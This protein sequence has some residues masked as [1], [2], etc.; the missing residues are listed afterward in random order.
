[1]PRLLHP[2]PVTA[3]RIRERNGFVYCDH[4]GHRFNSVPTL[5]DE[6]REN[7]GPDNNAAPLPWE[8]EAASDEPAASGP[9]AATAAASAGRARQLPRTPPPTD[10]AN[11][12][13]RRAAD[14]TAHAAHT[15]KHEPGGV[16]G[17]PGAAASAG[18]EAALDSLLQ[19]AAT[20]R[21]LQELTNPAIEWRG[22]RKWSGRNRSGSRILRAIPWVLAIVVL[23]AALTWM[24]RPSYFEPLA[25]INALRPLLQWLC[26]VAGCAV[27]GSNY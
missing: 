6:I 27:P 2:L 17:I 19:P 10:I 13:P 21:E 12:Q 24:M 11:P 23:G 14:D 8:E 18:A 7:T 22:R 5:V 16:P 9:W 25:Q 26:E 1:M 15:M 3:A 4:C 20:D